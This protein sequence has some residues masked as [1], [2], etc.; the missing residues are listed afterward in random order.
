MSWKTASWDPKVRTANRIAAEGAAWQLHKHFAITAPSEIDAERIAMARGVFVVDGRAPGTDAWLVRGKKLG[1]VRVSDAIRERGRRRFAIA[2][3]LGHWELHAKESQLGAL[4]QEADLRD[5]ANS[6]LEM[7]ANI[8]A[9]EFL[10]P[11]HLFRAACQ[12]RKPSLS[13]IKDLAKIFDTSLTATAMRYV[14]LAKQTCLVVFSEDGRVKFWRGGREGEYWLPKG[15]PIPDGSQA[16]QCWMNG[17][18]ESPAVEVPGRLWLSHLSAAEELS[19]VEES[20]RLGGYNSILS[21]LWI[22]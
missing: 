8:F 2:H 21:L 18:N 7:E 12:K 15:H 4:C 9:A 11:S 14:E 10:M 1:F 6:P 17:V 19:V 3:E 5:Y 16:W 20:M 13:L 22:N